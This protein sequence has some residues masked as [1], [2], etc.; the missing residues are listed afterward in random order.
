MPLPRTFDGIHHRR[1]NYARRV[2]TAAGVLPIG[3]WPLGELS[4]N[5]AICPFNAALNGAYTGVAFNYPGI[6]DGRS[7]PFWDGAND[8]CNVYTAG[9]ASAFNALAGTV[10]IWLRVASASVWADGVQRVVL[11]LAA[12]NN[13][14]IGINK[15]TAA[16]TLRAYY[17]AASTTSAATFTTNT[18]D[19]LCYGLTWD[20]AADQVKQYAN[21]V[22]QGA[23]VTGLQTWTGALGSTIC[24]LGA[25]ITT[26]TNVWSGTL[27]HAAVWGK[28][29]SANV[30]AALARVH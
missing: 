5:A 17:R 30:M 16:N 6:G 12:D 15:Q 1:R 26:P 25:L 28:A 18:L 20:K 13:N 2:L 24:N 14:E 21:G 4:G 10:M 3:Y 11:R 8:Y 19:W 27:A 23:T 9:L 29:L 7:A 22:Q